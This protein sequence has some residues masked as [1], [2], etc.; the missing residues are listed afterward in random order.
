MQQLDLSF[1]DFTCVYVNNDILS[2]VYNR[3]FQVEHYVEKPETFV[4]NTINCGVYVLG[5]GVLDHM[6]VIID[7]SQKFA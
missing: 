5:I 6:K 3:N 4:S 1:N 7:N 2:L